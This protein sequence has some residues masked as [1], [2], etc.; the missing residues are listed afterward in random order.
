MYVCK[1]VVAMESGYH[2][3]KAD[4]AWHGIFLD[5]CLIFQ[6]P[7]ALQ[8]KEAYSSC[9]LFVVAVAK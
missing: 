5:P 8:Q 7:M 4:M 2:S 6:Q 3:K 1:P 9:K